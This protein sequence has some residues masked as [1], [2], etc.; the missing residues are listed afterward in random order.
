MGAGWA[1]FMPVLNT[2]VFTLIFTRV[3]RIE[4]SVP[5]PLFAYCGLLPWNIFAVSLKTSVN[6]LVTNKAL[7]TEGL[8]PARDLPVL[9][10]ARVGD[11]FLRSGSASSPR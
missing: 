2:I 6:G 1:V 7:L 3:A 5:Y 8:F 10:H 4:T 11:R 9:D